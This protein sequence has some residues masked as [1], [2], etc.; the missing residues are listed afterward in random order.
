M[1]AKCVE[2]SGVRRPDPRARRAFK[3][4]IARVG[5]LEEAKGV[6]SVAFADE[7]TI[8][9]RILPW[10]IL[11]DCDK[12]R[13]IET[14]RAD[15]LDFKSRPS[16]DEELRLQLAVTGKYLKVIEYARENECD[17]PDEGMTMNRKWLF[18]QGFNP[19]N[20]PWMRDDLS[21]NE[22]ALWRAGQGV[23]TARF[24]A[25]MVNKD[26]K[27][28][29]RDMFS[30]GWEPKRY[31]KVPLWSASKATLAEAAAWYAQ[32]EEERQRKSA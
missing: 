20:T 22:W 23:I 30:Q 31:P 17:H 11:I 6:I 2:W 14:I 18:L 7:W 32:W 1:T 21:Q 4:L 8:A 25:L 16:T 15:Q 12:H 27:A 13:G 9:H 29:C 26:R 28:L 3:D 19:E 24:K 5:D 10:E